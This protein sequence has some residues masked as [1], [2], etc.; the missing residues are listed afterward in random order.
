[1]FFH[2][3]IILQAKSGYKLRNSKSKVPFTIK[4]KGVGKEGKG[5]QEVI[6]NYIMKESDMY[7]FGR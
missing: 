2:V 4:R 5:L 7:M 6:S 3:L 1:M